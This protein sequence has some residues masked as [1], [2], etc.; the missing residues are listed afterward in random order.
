MLVLD[1]AR[2][3]YQVD[4]QPAHRVFVQPLPYKGTYYSTKTGFTMVK[5]LKD[6][7]SLTHGSL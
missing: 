5:V 2:T 7:L 1:A 6:L 3:N 4:V